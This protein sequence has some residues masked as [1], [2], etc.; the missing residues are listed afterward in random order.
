MLNLL[1]LQFKPLLHDVYWSN[2]VGLCI[3]IRHFTFVVSSARLFA[4]IYN[5]PYSEKVGYVHPWICSLFSKHTYSLNDQHFCYQD[6]SKE[7]VTRV[8]ADIKIPE[9][10]P[11]D[12]VGFNVDGVFLALL[13]TVLLTVL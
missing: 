3:P 2:L 12:K 5:I 1:T 11:L 7:A 10:R 13:K 6:L 8:L 9:Y 4:G